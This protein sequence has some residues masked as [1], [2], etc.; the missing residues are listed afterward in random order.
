MRFVDKAP[1]KPGT[2][3]VFP[4]FGGQHVRGYIATGTVLPGWD[5]EIVISVQAVEEMVRQLGWPTVQE[6]ADAVAELERA[7][8][9]VE[10]LEADLTEANRIVDAIDAIES[11]DFRARKKAGRPK[12]IETPEAA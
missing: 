1:G 2:C 8:A 9:R 6:H 12:K 7:L 11:A 4:Q 3:A 10:H 5:P